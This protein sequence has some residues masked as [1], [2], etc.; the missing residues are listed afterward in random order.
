MKNHN[1]YHSGTNKLTET[2]IKQICEGTKYLM[3]ESLNNSI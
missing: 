3:K 1:A 2:K